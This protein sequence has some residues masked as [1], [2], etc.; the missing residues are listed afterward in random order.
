LRGCAGRRRQQEKEEGRFFHEQSHSI[1]RDRSAQV[2]RIVIE[3]LGAGNSI[4]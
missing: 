3:L 2:S 1:R 4:I